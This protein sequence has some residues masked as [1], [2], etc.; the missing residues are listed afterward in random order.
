[1]KG[2]FIRG[3]PEM[4]IKDILIDSCMLQSKEGLH[5]EE[6]EN[7]TLKNII[8]LSENTNPVVMIQNS[9]GINLD[10]IQYKK[11]AELLMSIGGDRTKNIKLLN[12]NTTLSKKEVEFRGS[13]KPS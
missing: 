12:T 7:V 10:N 2:I 5:C 9:N 3:L 11:D 4:S 13:T 1:E 8:I 6:A